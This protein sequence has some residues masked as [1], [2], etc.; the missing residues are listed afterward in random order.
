MISLQKQAARAAP[1]SVGQLL[2]T[3]GAGLDAEGLGDGLGEGDGL[4]LGDGDGLG[5]GGIGLG[6]VLLVAA[7]T[8]MSA[9]LRKTSGTVPEQLVLRQQVPMLRPPVTGLI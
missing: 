1:G 2:G 6:V 9:Q 3:G 5:L 8:R 4:A 7:R